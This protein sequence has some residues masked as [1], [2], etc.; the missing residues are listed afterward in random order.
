MSRY[1]WM[2]LI[3]GLI[4]VLFGISLVWILPDSPIKA[5]WLNDRERLIAV[6]RLKSNKTGV[7]NINHKEAQVKEALYDPKVWLLAAAIFF[8]NMT[9]SLQTTFQGI[10]LKGSATP[11]IKPCY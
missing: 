4:T 9:N 2:F 10:I 7:K 11:P 3:F 6:E 8:H 5:P 1:Q